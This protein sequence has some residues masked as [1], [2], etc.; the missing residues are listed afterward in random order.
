MDGEK[1]AWITETLFGRDLYFGFTN[2]GQLI[3]WRWT[4]APDEADDLALKQIRRAVIK[5]ADDDYGPLMSICRD[6]FKTP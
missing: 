5:W 4:A 2:G 1:C 3:P 6:G